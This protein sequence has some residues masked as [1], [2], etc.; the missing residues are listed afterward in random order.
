MTQQEYNNLLELIKNLSEQKEK[1]YCSENTKELFIALAKA[2]G[3]FP[4]SIGQENTNPHFKSKYASLDSIVRVVRPILSK[5]GLS[6]TQEERISGTYQI[7]LHT[8]LHYEDQ[9]TEVR[10]PI[11]PEKDNIQGYGSALSYGKRYSILSL[12]F[13]TTS[14]DPDDDDGESNMVY[15]RLKEQAQPA[16]FTSKDPSFHSGPRFSQAELSLVQQMLSNR[17]R[18]AQNL[19]D[20][21]KVKALEQLPSE[22]FHT[23][24]AKLEKNIQ[25]NPNYR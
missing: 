10:V 13:I 8:R 5:N 7:I 24:C 4:A 17:P 2:Q 22:E 25:N 14:E 11:R 18:L 19:L 3:E 20:S 16:P 1:P 23:I 12:L 15:S 21:Y 9:W 6:I